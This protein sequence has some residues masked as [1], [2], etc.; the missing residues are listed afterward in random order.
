MSRNTVRVDKVEDLYADIAGTYRST[1]TAA[2]PGAH[3][4]SDV[5]Q[6]ER[7]GYVVIEGLLS[8]QQCQDIAAAADP[9]LGSVG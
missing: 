2:A 1:A 7:D 5:A 3:V 4:D 6:L 9:L 8:P